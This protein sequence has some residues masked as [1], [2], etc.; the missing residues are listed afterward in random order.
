MVTLHNR[1]FIQDHSPVPSESFV[2]THLSAASPAEA[3]H[4]IAFD[5]LRDYFSNGAK[6]KA[7]WRV[8][9]EF[10]KFALDR[11]TGRQIGY[12]ES[13]GVREILESLVARFGWDPHYEGEHLTTLTRIGSCVSLEPGGQVEFS[14]LPVKH[15]GELAVE[16][17]RHSDEL[18]AVTDPTRIA[19]V[20]AGVTPFSRVE[21][22]PLGPRKR[23][24]VMA[25]YLPTKCPLAMHM[26][27]ATASTQVAFDYS[28]EADAVKK[29]A[30]ALALG[31]IINAVWGNSA[32]ANG[33][34]TGWASYRGKVWLG[35]DPDRSGVLHQLLADGLSF[36]R[37]V[38]Y[39]L[40]VPM[41]FWMREGD[42]EPAG[43]RTFREF[44]TRGIEDYYPTK[45]DW[46]LHLT[47]VFP[48]VRLKHFLEVR[49]ADANP[50]PL[51]LA[52]PAFWKGLLYDEA[53]LEAAAAIASQFPP[54]TLP[55]LFAS[56]S[57]RGLIAKANGRTVKAWATE[58]TAIAREGLRRQA[59]ANGHADE[60]HF[61]D[62]VSEVLERGQSPGMAMLADR[63]L[64]GSHVLRK[65]EY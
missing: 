50:P 43:G 11:R 37:W 26:M 10:E 27:K 54:K 61:L 13:H 32:F 7:D 23:H 31:P 4:P 57:E 25:E 16:L 1:A 24:A 42:Y 15:V 45:F 46:E 48:E 56:A 34:P 12:D 47:T 53:A 65:L 14:S 41:L 8:G 58:L 51:A 33:E 20:A 36:A 18:R 40:D 44:M 64:N 55:D 49:G 22:I 3:Q 59:A 62:P 2:S 6:P 52:V 19:W 38:D 60:T 17:Y 5:E 30:T 21:S 9:A 35:M 39:L 28:D 63:P 29:F